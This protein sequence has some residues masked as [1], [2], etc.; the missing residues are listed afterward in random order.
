MANLTEGERQ[1]I[2]REIAL[3]LVGHMDVTTP[4]VWVESLLKSPPTVCSNRL[5]LIDTLT[6]VLAAFYEWSQ[7]GWGMILVPKKMPLA[8]R[9]FAVANKLFKS[10]TTAILERVKELRRSLD[11]ELGDYA[12]YFARVFLAPDPLVE[13]YRKQGRPLQGFAEAFLIPERVAVARWQDP[14]FVDP[15]PSKNGPRFSHS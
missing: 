3:D 8:E 14:L 9:R 15:S 4:P 13:S 6:D 7:G 11:P 2:V 10:M 5:C 1:D 12:E